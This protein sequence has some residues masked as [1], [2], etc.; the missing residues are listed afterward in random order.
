MNNQNQTSTTTSGSESSSSDPRD[1]LAWLWLLVGLS[2]LPFTFY[3]T[4]I[5]LAAWLAP[6]F[7]L[8]FERTARRRW[9]A[10]LMIFAVYA[11][12][13]LIALRGS[14][15][16]N[17]G[18]F[19]YGLIVFPL[20]R[21]LMYTLPYAA[22]RLLG[23]RRGPWERVF[24]FPLAFTTADWLLTLR[25]VTNSTGSLAYSQY[26]NLALIQILS[27]TGMWGITFL[28]AW[29]ASTANALWE[30]AFDLRQ[31]R[32]IVGTFAATL[33]AILL[34]GYARLDFFPPSS[35]QVPVAAITLDDSVSRQAHSNIDW[36][37]FNQS[38]DAQRAAART[39]FSAIM[40]ELFK[41]TETALRGGA[42]L[43]A[44]QEGAGT[45]LEEDTAAT[46]ARAGALAK[47]YDAYLEV[48]LGVLTRTP[49]QHYI[50]NESV[51]VDNTGAVR[52]IYD[53]TYLVIP[54]ESLVSIPGAGL[55]PYANTPYGLLS[56]AICNDLHFP[57]LIRQ[58]GR[59]NA[60]VLITPYDDIHPFE[61][62]DAVSATYRAIENG[63]S[64][65]R[66]AGHGVSTIADYQGR[67]L[68]S[69]DYYTDKSGVLLN[70]IPLRGVITVYSRIGDLFAYLCA[71]GLITLTVWALL[72]TKKDQAEA[73]KS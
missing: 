30:H 46:L 53:K 4:V 39:Q 43:V 28:L 63:F 17:A 7:L 31:V 45:V 55:L 29:F 57:P 42:K 27:I 9:L 12:S 20:M 24:I 21:G 16:G 52:W 18:L 33:L 36:L 1:R 54:V 22:D 34:F 2:L 13:I 15:S 14:V 25:S 44:W 19:I 64:V 32:A 65:V 71:A 26:N 67:I 3:Q 47:A 5:P 37:S 38:T 70:T 23:A 50:R 35:P 60:D 11:V 51:L 58:A 68:A 6:V 10:I 69:R 73:A 62:E 61:S 72:P 56:T 48:S 59:G 66:P 41:R 49:S 8:R 40:D